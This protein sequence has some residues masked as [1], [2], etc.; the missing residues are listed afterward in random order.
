M[1]PYESPKTGSIKRRESNLAQAIGCG[2][3]IVVLNLAVCAAGAFAFYIGGA[4]GII[5]F[6]LCP[7]AVLALIAVWANLFPHR[8]SKSRIKYLRKKRKAMKQQ[9]EGSGDAEE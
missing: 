2:C 9:R 1:N 5:L 7:S 8:T 6:V 3:L 4:K